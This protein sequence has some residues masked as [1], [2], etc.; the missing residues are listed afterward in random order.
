LDKFQAWQ[1]GFIRFMDT[2]HPD[3]GR[4]ITTGNKKMD[5]ATIQGLRMAL[6]AYNST[7][8]A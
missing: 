3:I 7:F 6:E 2:G 8:A 1:D 5:D 4:T